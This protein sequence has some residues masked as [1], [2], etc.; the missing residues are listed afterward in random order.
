MTTVTKTFTAVGNGNDFRLP[1]GQSFDYDV[2]GT[3]VGTV[4]LEHTRNG[5]ITYEPVEKTL[6]APGSGL[7]SYPGNEN[8]NASYRWRCS[9]FTSGSIVTSM[10]DAVDAVKGS[11]PA[12]SPDIID[13]EGEKIFGVVDGSVNVLTRTSQKKI[14][15]AGAKV[16]GTAGWLID[17]AND[18]GS[19]AKCPA[20][21]TAVTMVIKVP[22]LKVG[23]V[24]TA[25][26]ANGQI[27]SGG[28]VATLDLELLKQT[29]VA[30]GN[31]ESSI[32]SITQVSVT[33]D[34]IVN[35]EKADLDE[36]VVEGAQY[37]LLATATTA[38][39]TDIDLLN[40]T[41]TVTEK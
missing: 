31:T 11:N 16:G 2:S 25:F 8:S 39:A 36:T 9:A 33:A 23:D 6:A 3:F 38:A 7:I 34:T 12:I 28:N 24:I 41:V 32:G 29:A 14:I 21:E 10:A 19:L 30:A 35:S 40:A 27:E 15:T 18:K 20:A 1:P 17:A 26:G 13:G 4:V 22:D 37:Y 5:G